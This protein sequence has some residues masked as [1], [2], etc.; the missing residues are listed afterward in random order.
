MRSQRDHR[1]AHVVRARHHV[2]DDF[3]VGGIRNR[4][5]Q[6]PDDRGAARAKLNALADHGGIA[7]ERVLPESIGQHRNAGSVEPFVRWLDEAADR[8]AQAHHAEILPVDDPGL[9]DARLA[10]ADQREFNG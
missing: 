8:R 6:H 9:D 3:G 10:E 1:R 7:A 4:G 2:G 5:L